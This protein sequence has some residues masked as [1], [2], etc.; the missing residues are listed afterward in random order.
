[1]RRLYNRVSQSVSSI[2]TSTSTNIRIRPRFSG[3]FWM[4]FVGWLLFVVFIWYIDLIDDFYDKTLLTLL[5]SA[6]PLLALFSEPS[7]DASQRRWSSWMWRIGTA[8]ALFAV[9]VGISDKWNLQALG[10]AVTMIGVSSPL[11][12]I[13]LYLSLKKRL[14][15]FAL[16]PSIIAAMLHAVAFAPG[17]RFYGML[18]LLFGILFIS[19]PWAAAGHFLL[20]FT[21]RWRRHPI[22]G[23]GMECLTMIILFAPTIWLVISATRA[24]T[25]DDIWLALSLTI[26]GVLISSIVST[27]FRRLLLALGNLQPLGACESDDDGWC[28]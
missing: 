22:R 15:G 4:I 7:E 5:C 9:L 23:S 17:D 27:P 12:A 13:C 21:E 11:L 3:D 1:M 24:I 18:V 28:P 20:Q 10:I 19:I 2:W 14:L 8:F 6:L 16:A 25:S 26:V